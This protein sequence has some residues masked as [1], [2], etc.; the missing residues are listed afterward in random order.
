MF[1]Y[2]RGGAEIT[3][4]S[5]DYQNEYSGRLEKD[6]LERKLQPKIEELLAK[7][8]SIEI[9]RQTAGPSDGPLGN[10]EQ[11][12]L[13][14]MIQQQ[15]ERSLSKEFI[16]SVEMKYGDKITEELQTESLEKHIQ[17]TQSRLRLEIG[18]LNRRGIVNLIIGSLTTLVAVGILA[19][20][21]LDNSLPTEPDKL[22]AHFLPR[23]TL[24]IFIEI[25]S[26]FFLRLYSSGLNDIKYYQNELTNIESKFI[27]LRRALQMSEVGPLTEILQK[28]AGT[29][30]NFVLKKGETTVD[31]EK[32]KLDKESLKEM[33]GAFADSVKTK[34]K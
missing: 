7:F 14:E 17:V 24:S 4:A 19:S 8:E 32:S 30:R 21:I 33:L 13:I 2:L 6:W 9:Q 15:L 26:F 29:E 16:S 1:A 5:R 20:S 28:L 12:Q 3:L 23:I 11:Q 10:D 31:L 34:K 27:A 22:A 18:S 25:F